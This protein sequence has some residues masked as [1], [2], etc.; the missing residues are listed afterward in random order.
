MNNLNRDDNERVNASYNAGADKMTE[1]DLNDILGKEEKFN[2]KGA[3][4]GSSWEKARL[5]FDMIK[6]YKAG[7]YTE[8]PWKV[9]AA[10]TF[11]IVYFFWPFDVIPDI[12]IGLGYTDDIAVFAIVLSQ[13]N[14]QIE[15]YKTWRAKY[16]P[17]TGNDK[18]V[19]KP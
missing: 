10:I 11:A 19:I 7:R 8:V 17:K 4:L 15:A 6:D 12:L 18:N 16:L 9:I 14:T 5:L 2:K 1:N 13:F 3:E